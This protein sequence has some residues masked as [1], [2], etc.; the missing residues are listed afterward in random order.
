M[1]VSCSDSINE[2]DK[3]SNNPANWL[4]VKEKL[5]KVDGV[6]SFSFLDKNGETVKSVDIKN[7]QDITYKYYDSKNK[8]YYRFGPGG[9][10]S[11]NMKTKEVKHLIK[12]KDINDVRITDGKLYYY[13]N[14]GFVDDKYRVDINVLNN[15]FSLKLNYFVN[16][17][18]VNDDKIYVV[19]GKQD[20]DE[21]SI[22]RI[23][24]GN[25]LE[26]EIQVKESGS[27]YE[28]DNTVY[29]LMADSMLNLNTNQRFPI[30]EDN[31]PVYLENTFHAFFQ[32]SSSLYFINDELGNIKLYTAELS[33]GKFILQE[34]K[35]KIASVIGYEFDGIETFIVM[36]ADSNFYSYSIKSGKT[37]MLNIPRDDLNS[38]LLPIA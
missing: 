2:N 15:D 14:I 12:D 30:L 38:S 36:D 6:T 13:E 18:Y 16:D 35:L 19:N 11:A 10:V 3:L 28:L 32:T 23:Y 21:Q 37:E 20:S 34:I 17:F 24:R 25:K 27:F 1:L 8:T 22:V 29:Y 26:K 5:G 4:L 9:L 31:K 7:G 33:D